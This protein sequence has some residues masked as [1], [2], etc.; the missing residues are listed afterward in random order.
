MPIAPAPTMTID[1]GRSR[2]RICSSYVTTFPPSCTPGSRRTFEPVEM[3]ALS[4]VTRSVEPSA[5]FDVDRVRVDER[6]AAVVLGD[7]VLLHQEVDA[8]DVGV[9]DLAA[10]IPRG[11]E[12]ERHVAR[13]AEQ[14]GL[15]VERVREVGVLAGAPWRGCSPTLRQ[16]P[17]QYFSSMTATERPS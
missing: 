11:A 6:A 12:V 2:A 8:L 3:I 7:L 10:A 13:D 9:G 16:T 15:V 4:N 1:S 5:F 17:P 14:L